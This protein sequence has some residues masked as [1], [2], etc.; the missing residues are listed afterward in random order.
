MRILFKILLFSGLVAFAVPA[1]AQIHLSINIGPPAP[2][3]EVIVRAPFSGAI[4]IAGYYEYNNGYVW[5]SGRWEAPPAPGQRWV[6]PRYVRRGNHYDY[7]AGQWK[8]RG[9]HKGGNPHG[10]GGGGN[11]HG[12]G[13]G[14]NPHGD[15]KG[16]NPHD[17]GNGG[18]P[19]G[20]GRR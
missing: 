8:D 7:Y 10:D 2:R 16:G 12:N 4:W 17:N 11:P 20:N 5:Q 19:H 13:N 3:R 9:K 15:G 18:N 14:G 6:S 1:F